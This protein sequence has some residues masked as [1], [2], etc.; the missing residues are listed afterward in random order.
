T[1]SAADKQHA[2]FS[3]GLG[4]QIKVLSPQAY[5]MEDPREAARLERKVDPNAWVEK[6]L[7]QYLFPGAE[8][9]SVGCGPGTILPAICESHADSNVTGLDLSPLR[10]RQAAERNRHNQ[11][12]HFFCGDAREMRFASDT[13]DVVYTRMML[14]YVAEKEKAVAEMVRVCKP[15]G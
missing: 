7:K 9:L 11:R 6:Y 14:Q 5:I 13:F 8:V 12:A 3:H 15:G 1:T 4:M 2:A 10:V